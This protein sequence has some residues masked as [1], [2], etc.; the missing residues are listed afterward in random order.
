MHLPF[1]DLLQVDLHYV[2]TDNHLLLVF[3]ENVNELVVF[4]VHSIEYYPGC[5]FMRSKD[6]QLLGQL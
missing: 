6:D 1:P 4:A 3:N 5:L 2:L